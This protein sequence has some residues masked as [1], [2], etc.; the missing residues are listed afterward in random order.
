MVNKRLWG[1]GIE[2]KEPSLCLILNIDSRVNEKSADFRRFRVLLFTS[3]AA[4]IKKKN[5]R[6]RWLHNGDHGL[7]VAYAQER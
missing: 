6:P 4:K 7:C 5:E 3:P 2:T 1:W